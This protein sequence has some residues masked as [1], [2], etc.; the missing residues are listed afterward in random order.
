MLV[1]GAA[2]TIAETILIALIIGQILFRVVSKEA[3]E[4]IPPLEQTAVGIPATK[5]CC[6]C[7]S[8]ATKSLFP[9]RSWAI[10]T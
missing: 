10:R 5:S 3:N 1:L 2:Y 9:Y 4:P 6:I 7:R 8:T